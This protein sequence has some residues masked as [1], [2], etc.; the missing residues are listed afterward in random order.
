MR[1]RV[2][3]SLS[4]LFLGSCA[5]SQP[6]PVEPRTN[7]L[8]EQRERQC[9]DFAEEYEKALRWCET[10]QPITENSRQASCQ[11]ARAHERDCLQ[12]G[13]DAGV[14]DSGVRHSGV[15]YPDAGITPDS[16]PALDAGVPDVGR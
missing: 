9:A 7:F 15:Q 11:T 16:G 6:Q 10:S 4:L 8:V 1:E 2:G 5:S 12:M 14:Q 13:T 3:V